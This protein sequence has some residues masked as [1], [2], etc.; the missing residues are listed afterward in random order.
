LFKS[1]L[2]KFV[3][4]RIALFFLIGSVAGFLFSASRWLVILGLAVGAAVGFMRFAG[5][6]WMFRN[7]TSAETARRSGAVIWNSLLYIVNQLV[8][9]A[10]LYVAYRVDT[11][12]LIG[13]AAG[14]LLPALSLILNCLTELLGITKNHFFM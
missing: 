12:L 11:S 8:L 2:E 14:T 9:L 1:E 3:A 10:L 6:A 13:F 4:Q 7:I 5:Y